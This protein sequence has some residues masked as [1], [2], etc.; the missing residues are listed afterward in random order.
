M[1]RVLTLAFGVAAL[2]VAAES[3][4]AQSASVTTTG[5]A[6]V[7]SPLTLT[8]STDLAFGNIVR[9]SSGSNTITIDSASGNRTL[10]GGGNGALA[11][12]TST[13]ASYSVQGEGGQS[14]SIT[15]PPSLSLTRSGG[16]ET[17]PVTLSASTSGALSGAVGDAGVA[18][19]GVGG[20]LQLD[21]TA[22]SGN[23]SGTFNVTIGYN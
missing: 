13:R 8:K 20:S 16:T 19:F 12:S 23:Y 21:S 14:F 11:S 9:P 3:A 6:T 10:L 15:I 7:V 17:L 18:S 22:V 5:T 1:K 2:A 4:Y